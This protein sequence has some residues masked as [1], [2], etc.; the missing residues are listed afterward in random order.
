VSAASPRAGLRSRA[1][2][3][4][5][6]MGLR[7]SIL[8]GKFALSLF[9]ARYL[10]LKML[11][12][13]GLLAAAAIIVPIVMGFGLIRTITRHAVRR[14]L[15]ELAS[16]LVQYWQVQ[17]IFYGSILLLAAAGVILLKQPLVIVAAIAILWLER[18]NI[19]FFTVMN[20]LR[21]F[22]LANGLMFIGSTGW[23]IAFMVSAIIWPSLRNLESLVTFWIG[24]G[25]AALFCFA[26]VTRGWPWRQSVTARGQGGWLRGQLR[27]SGVLYVNDVVN[28]A[29][30]YLDRY[31]VGLLLGLEAAGVYVLFWSIGNALNSL[32]GTAV[33][34]P[35]ETDLISAH[36]QQE[37]SYW[38][39]FEKLLTE[40]VVASFALAAASGLL[41]SAAL[42]HL[43]FLHA[44]TALPVFWLILCGFIVRMAYEVQ[45]TVL[46]SRQ[47][48]RL[49]L[50][51]GVL[52]L[53]ISVAGNLALAP[54]Y[55]LYV[56]A[57]VFI[58]SYSMGAIA[59][60][61][62]ISSER[63][64]IQDIRS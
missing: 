61:R 26:Y 14:P 44:G 13:Y 32:I 40:T 34:Y 49:T 59:R 17:A 55:S 38:P 43:H 19:D 50:A 36:K 45:G 20:H 64:T 21:R 54:V 60:H 51:T 10:D 56:P 9:I 3:S 39:L 12:V 33:I 35:S 58:A 53:A 48:D 25:L 24:G 31:V 52:V 23:M 18:L 8:L 16:M 41:V 47:K 5:M 30:Q 46:F 42:P 27:Q 7:G 2:T 22:H 1:T 11:G 37:P 63:K 62:L 57:I 6:I 29:G 15:I 4:L 28:V